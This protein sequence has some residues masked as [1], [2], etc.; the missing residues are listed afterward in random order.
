M[1]FT[2]RFA[3]SGILKNRQIYIPY[4]LTGVVNVA[5]FYMLATLAYH[6]KIQ[7]L[8]D[9]DDDTVAKMLGYG[10]WI[11]GLFS[12]VFL[13]YSNSFLLKHRQKEFGL[14]T[15]LGMGRREIARSLFCEFLMSTGI[16]LAGGLL[17]GLLLNRLAFLLLIRIMNIKTILKPEFSSKAMLTT[18]VLFTC[19]FFVNFLRLVIRI[20]SSRPI[21]LVHGSNT[22][23]KEPR[24]KWI[25]L[26]LGL[27]SL[28]AGYTLALTQDHAA[29][30]VKTFFI[31]V[32]L[33]I[34]GTYCLFIAVSIAVLKLLRRKKSFYYKP[35]NFTAVSG[36]LYR[37]KQNGVGLASISI[38]STMVLLTIA[39]TVSLVAGIDGF[40]QNLYPVDLSVTAMWVSPENE[41]RFTETIRK[42]ITDSGNTVSDETSYTYYQYLGR[43]DRNRIEIVLNPDIFDDEDDYMLTILTDTSYEK[44]TGESLNL[45]HGEAVLESSSDFAYDTMSVGHMRFSVHRNEDAKMLA[46][47]AGEPD[48]Y[49]LILTQADIDLILMEYGIDGKAKTY[50][51]YNANLSGTKEQQIACAEALFKDNSIVVDSN[52][53]ARGYAFSKARDFDQAASTATAYYGGLFFVGIFLGIVFLLGTVLVI[54]YKQ[55]SEGYEDAERFS[56]MRKVGMS[57]DEIRSTIRRQIILIF[58]LPLLVAVVHILV[59][60]RYMTQILQLMG[61]EYTQ[62]FLLCTGG[63]I[64]VFALVYGAVYLLTAKAY[65]RIVK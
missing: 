50:Y 35:G 31:A 4:L 1:P 18:A 45:K 51:S 44:N 27:A 10:V 53:S 6:S 65:Y 14:Y 32:L 28:G 16:A 2:L 33:V 30:A 40:L 8:F 15:V 63:C 59:A 3:F 21:E 61:F 17:I 47:E 39:M 36:M 12:L 48:R 26:I 58:F 34:F 23:E 7:H 57:Q 52:L 64:L 42:T 22:G 20:A 9:S 13:F 24:I 11:V 54:Y 46:Y 41:A 25:L 38:L 56:V 60:F 29:K 43:V 37:M 55:I 62:L 5:L 19:I 49:C